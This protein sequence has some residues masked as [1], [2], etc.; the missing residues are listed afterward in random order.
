MA[1]YYIQSG[2]AKMVLDC[3]DSERASLWFIH[4]AME[5]VSPVYEDETLEENLKLDSAIVESLIDLG[6][7]IDISE[8]GFDRDDAEK[9]ETLDVIMYWHQLMMA[10]SRLPK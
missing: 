6:A 5:S 4:R 10:L 7:T 1:K 3:E 8:L 9:L 2:T